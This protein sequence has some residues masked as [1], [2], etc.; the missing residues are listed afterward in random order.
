LSFKTSGGIPGFDVQRIVSGL[1]PV[2]GASLKWV[3][4]VCRAKLMS[5]DDKFMTRW[6]VKK[7]WKM[8]MQLSP[9]CTLATTFKADGR[10][11]KQILRWTRNTWRSDVKSLVLERIIWYRYPVQVRWFFTYLGSIYTHT[12]ICSGTVWPFPRPSWQC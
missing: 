8:C 11:F 3:D 5:G 6:V 1:K 2:C 12:H 4:G 10:F 7:G 9:E